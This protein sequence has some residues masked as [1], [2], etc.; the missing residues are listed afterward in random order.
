MREA[1]R[2]DA[3]LLY[4]KATLTQATVNVSTAEHIQASFQCTM[5]ATLR[6]SDSPVSIRFNSGVSVTMMSVFDS[7]AVSFHKQL[8][9]YKPLGE[10]DE[11]A[12]GEIFFFGRSVRLIYDSV[13]FCTFCFGPRVKILRLDK[14]RRRSGGRCGGRRIECVESHRL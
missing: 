6:L 13:S 5:V 1:A 3:L 11:Q 10:S 4:A 2:F 12:E 7:H 8:E 14:E 9:G